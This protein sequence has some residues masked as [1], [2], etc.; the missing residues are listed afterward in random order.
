MTERLRGGGHRSR[1]PMILF[2]I[3]SVA[4]VFVQ[5]VSQSADFIVVENPKRLVAYDSYQRSL[6]KAQRDALQPFMPMKILEAHGIFGDGL[7]HYTKV[8]ADGSILYLLEDENGMLAG[9]KNLGTIK[10]FEGEAFLQDTISI[11]VSDRMPFL[12]PTG[13]KSFLA[14]GDRCV[15]YFNDAGSWYVKRLGRHPSYGWLRNAK[16]KKGEWREIVRPQTVHSEFSSASLGRIG[17]R[18]RQANQVLAQV[19]ALL[20]LETGKRLAPP[21]WHIDR[22]GE[23]L[24]I[25]LLPDSAL[26]YYPKSVEALNALLQT[27]VLGTGLEA[28]GSGNGI[29]ITRR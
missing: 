1:P 24:R 9:R 15:R 22:R 20:N 5:A 26:R 12:S 11:L 16:N 29:N 18:I 8:E 27:Y 17:E 3:V 23:S 25:E 14:A 10:T 6:T 7:T 2:L 4:T 21:Q 28:F 13:N 19:Y